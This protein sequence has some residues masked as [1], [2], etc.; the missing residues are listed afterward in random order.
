LNFSATKADLAQ[1]EARMVAH[2]A[3][4]ERRLIHWFVGTAIT[5]LQPRS[6]LRA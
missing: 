6:A 2:M 4:L 3:E 5:L 1:L